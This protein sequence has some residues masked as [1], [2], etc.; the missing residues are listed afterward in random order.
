MI[1]SL[2][3]SAILL[4]LWLGER[5]L[6]QSFADYARQTIATRLAVSAAFHSPAVAGAV[7][8]MRDALDRVTFRPGAPVFANSTAAEY[9]DE[10]PAA[11][12]LLAGQLVRPVEFV[13]QVERMYDAGVRT[14]LEVGPGGRLTGLVSQILHGRPHEDNALRATRP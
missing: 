11:R 14:F 6:D 3:L 5:Q 9:P 1:P 4:A 2:A 10:A 8:P 12:D 7:P 13:S